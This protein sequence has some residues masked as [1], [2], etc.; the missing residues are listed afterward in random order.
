MKEAD[1]GFGDPRQLVSRGPT[2]EVC[3]AFSGP[4]GQCNGGRYPALIDTGATSNAIDV[5]LAAELDLPVIDQQTVNGV[6]GAYNTTRHLG[7]IYIPDLGV[8]L[9]GAFTAVQ[10]SASGQMH[11]VL[12]GRTL[13]RNMQMLY[14]G[15]TG[16]V[17]LT[18]E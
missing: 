13:L 3:V 10:L 5:S 6:A 11:R 8:T 2:I 7:Q 1:C 14:D 4:L 16:R 17:N 18:I 15:P 12:L 9:R